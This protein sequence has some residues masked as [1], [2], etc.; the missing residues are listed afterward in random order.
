MDIEG[1]ANAVETQLK[2]MIK[3]IKMLLIFG[4]IIDSPG[5]L[6]EVRVRIIRYI[7]KFNKNE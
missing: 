3:P 2:T 1:C 7:F 5:S 4:A 6:N